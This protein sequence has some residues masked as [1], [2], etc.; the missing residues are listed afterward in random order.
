M[1][2]SEKAELTVSVRR[3]ERFS[4]SG[5][6]IFN[7]DVPDTAYRKTTTTARKRTQAT[8]LQSVMMHFKRT[9]L[10]NIN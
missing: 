10:K 7:S 4:K 3:S 1:N 9:Q 5:I 8:A 2:T 6:V